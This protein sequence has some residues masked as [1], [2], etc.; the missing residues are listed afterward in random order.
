[1]VVLFLPLPSLLLVWWS[2]GYLR[3]VCTK[4]LR[5]GM[6]LHL[7]S[8]LSLVFVCRIQT[9]RFRTGTTL[10]PQEQ[11]TEPSPQRKTTKSI[12]TSKKRSKSKDKE[13]RLH[14]FTRTRKAET[15]YSEGKAKFPENSRE[16]KRTTNIPHHVVSPQKSPPRSS[17]PRNTST[18]HTKI[19][20]RNHYN[21]YN[22]NLRRNLNNSNKFNRI[23]LSVQHPT[24]LILACNDHTRFTTTRSR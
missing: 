19:T 13:T 7:S 24:V 10:K 23:S 3:S 1:L 8:P 6:L 18:C 17:I 20:N 4:P 12:I 15:T 9:K 2:Y 22:H 16:R 21:V 14:S 5:V 11:Q